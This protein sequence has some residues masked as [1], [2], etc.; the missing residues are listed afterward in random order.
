MSLVIKNV[1][2]DDAGTYAVKATN[3]LGADSGHIQLNV[4]G[5]FIFVLFK[6]FRNFP[7]NIFVFSCSNN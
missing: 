7:I 5:I 3:E 2:M 6:H 1:S 4:K